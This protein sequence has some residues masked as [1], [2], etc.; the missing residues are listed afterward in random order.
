MEG[1]LASRS[2]ALNGV[3][4]GIDEVEWNPKLDKMISKNYDVTS[5]KEGKA[6]NKAAL[7]KELSLPVRPD[8]SGLECC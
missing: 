1:L 4:N 7:Q 2:Y 6:A 5:F 3:L 8:V